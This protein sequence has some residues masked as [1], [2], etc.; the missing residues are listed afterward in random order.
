MTWRAISARPYVEVERRE[1][2]DCGRGSVYS[3][4]TDEA[5]AIAGAE[6]DALDFARDLAASEECR[7]NTAEFGLSSFDF[8]PRSSGSNISI[9]PRE[10]GSIM[11]EEGSSSAGPGSSS[12]EHGSNTGEQGSSTAG[13]GSSTAE[14]GS[15]S[16]EHGS[17]TVEPGSS[18]MER[19]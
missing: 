18:S 7:F 13:Q 15:S 2:V 16:A 8:T 12:V 11:A 10:S 17:N 3:Y 6:E 1:S 14:Q 5:R 4:A 19:G 9:T